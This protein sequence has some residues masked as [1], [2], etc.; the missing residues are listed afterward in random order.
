MLKYPGLLTVK[1]LAAL[2]H[3]ELERDNWGAIDT[4]L[5]RS[6]L[7][8]NT[9]NWEAM[10]EVLKRVVGRVNIGEVE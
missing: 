4:F 3:E 6:D 8:E 5:F 10:Q 1:R 2:L 9:E 7:D